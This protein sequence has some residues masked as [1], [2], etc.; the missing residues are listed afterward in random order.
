MSFNSP[1]FSKY[2]LSNF[3]TFIANSHSN[4]IL[5]SIPY[6]DL[7]SFLYTKHHEISV[8]IISWV[9]SKFLTRARNYT[10]QGPEIIPI[11]G[12]KL[13]EMRVRNFMSWSFQSVVRKNMYFA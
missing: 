8:V 1:F 7:I 13:N 9:F 4:K 12:Q 3:G 11:E 2:K 10:N 6:R 5:F